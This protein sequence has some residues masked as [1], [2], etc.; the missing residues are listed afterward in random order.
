M[1]EVLTPEHRVQRLG[2]SQ[3]LGGSLRTPSPADNLSDDRAQVGELEDLSGARARKGD[4]VPRGRKRE[5]EALLARL[6]SA[7][8]EIAE[9]ARRRAPEYRGVGDPLA[10]GDGEEFEEGLRLVV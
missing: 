9:L 3:R 8:E 6:V 5:R 7:L 1:P 4:V 10:S 2:D